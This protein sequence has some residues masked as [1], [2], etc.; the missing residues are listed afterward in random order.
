MGSAICPEDFLFCHIAGQAKELD[1]VKQEE[2]I[3]LTISDNGNGMTFIKALIPGCVASFHGAFAIGDHIQEINGN[4]A[5]GLRHF[6]VASILKKIPIGETIH[7]RLVSPMTSG[8]CMF[9][10]NQGR[11]F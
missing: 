10:F 6:D 4:S 1:L 8:F 7:F 2:Q 9:F 11:L 3:G 5:V